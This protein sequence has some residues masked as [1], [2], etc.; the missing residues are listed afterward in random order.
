MPSGTTLTLT[1]D[2]ILST[3]LFNYSRRLY[4]NI[5]KA[6]ALLFMLMRV[7][8]GGY[9]TLES[10][11]DR[12][13]VPLMYELG[14]ADSYSGYDQLDVTPMD[15]ITSAHWDWRQASVPVAIS[16]LDEKKNSGEAKIIDLLESKV[17]QADMGLRDFFNTRLLIGAGGSSIQTAYTS[18]L[19]GS[20]FLDPLPLLID[21][22]PTV[23]QTI[24]NIDQSVHSW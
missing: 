5:S 20:A 23:S 10:I 9:K 15:G 13:Q 21:F 14:S 1:Y 6:N 7:R 24:G 16:G 17:K 8:E 12:M 4:D 11:G 3:T 22:T 19:N 2:E 18:S